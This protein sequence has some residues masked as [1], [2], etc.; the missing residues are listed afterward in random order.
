MITSHLLEV[1][2]TVVNFNIFACLLTMVLYIQTNSLVLIV[3]IQNLSSQVHIQLVI[4]KEYIH[5]CLV[6]SSFYEQLSLNHRHTALIISIP[7]LI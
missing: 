7:K 6:L 1:N 5:I 4:E 3:K 2:N